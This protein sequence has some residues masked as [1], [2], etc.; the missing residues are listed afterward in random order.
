MAQAVRLQASPD[1][2]QVAPG[3]RLQIRLT[4]TNA[5][6]VI[7]RFAVTIEGLPSSWYSLDRTA[8]PLFPGAS[9]DLYLTLH[10]PADPSATAGAYPMT[11]TAT[12]ES[13][14]AQAATCRVVLTV[15][16]KGGMR[17]ELAP[18]A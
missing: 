14:A 11:I 1:A 15:A 4:L 12:S 9:D 18:T 5:S 8:A 17:L 2:A 6:S 7:D 3:D 10:P 13:S 16:R